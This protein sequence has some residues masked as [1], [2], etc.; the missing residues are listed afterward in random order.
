[1]SEP[2]GIIAGNGEFP[3]LLARTARAQGLHTVAA[4]FE[5]ETNSEIGQLANEVEWVRLGQLNRLIEVFTKRKVTRAVMAGG[6]TP[7]NLYKNLS[8][9]LRMIGVA[10]RLK[11][12]NAQTIFGAIAD[13][14]AKDGVQ[15]LDPRPFFGDQVP[16]PGNLTHHTP[17]RDQEDDIAFGL[18]IAK[19]VA[20]LDIGQTVV[21]KQGTVL[22]VEGFEGSDECIKRGGQLAGEKGGAVVVKVAKPNHDFRFDIPCVGVRTIESCAAGKIAVLAIEAAATLLLDREKVL[23]AADKQNLR[24]VAVGQASSLS[25]TPPKDK[26]DACPTGT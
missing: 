26:Q 17:D 15:L 23:E 5:G 2:L 9:D 25:T 10:A 13:E 11:V 19:A 21:V 1:M 18:K 22:A 8:L 12:R 4:A 20:A 24:I 6:I 7:A 3:L 14:C 16:Q